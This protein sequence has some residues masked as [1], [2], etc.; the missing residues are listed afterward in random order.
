MVCKVLSFGSLSFFRMTFKI[1][2]G[3]LWYDKCTVLQDVE[4]V[5][6]FMAPSNYIVTMVIGSCNLNVNHY[7]F[8][9]AHS[10]KGKIHRSCTRVVRRLPRKSLMVEDIWE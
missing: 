8:S 5:D 6:L 10:E 2:L 7:W 1:F 3:C 4:I 9:S